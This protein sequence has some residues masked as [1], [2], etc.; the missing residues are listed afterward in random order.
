MIKNF[1]IFFIALLALMISVTLSA[2]DKKL[3]TQ[4]SGDSCT[5]SLNWGDVIFRSTQSSSNNDQPSLNNPQEL[6]SFLT[7]ELPNLRKYVEDQQN[8]ISHLTNRVTNLETDLLDTKK[9]LTGLK[10][11]I[12]N[13]RQQKTI[14]DSPHRNNIVVTN[15]GMMGSS[16]LFLSSIYSGNTYTGNSNYD[17][18][19]PIALIGALG[20][21]VYVAWAC[22][23]P[24]VTVSYSR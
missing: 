3:T 10:S 23:Q 6:I 11:L 14:I 20:F 17:W 1:K 15:N 7:K 24:A 18:L 2:S 13:F 12:E 4:F 8:S 21:A 5:H 22:A 19:E 9:E 16:S